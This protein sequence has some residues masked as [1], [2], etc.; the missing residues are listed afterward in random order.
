[1]LAGRTAPAASLN[2]PRTPPRMSSAEIVR[3][4]T[5]IRDELAAALRGED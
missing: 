2:R 4:L 1:M 5:P 3:L